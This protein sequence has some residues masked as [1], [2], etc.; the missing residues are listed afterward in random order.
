MRYSFMAG[1]ALSALTFTT[2]VFAEDAGSLARSGEEVFDDSCAGCHTGGFAGFFGGAPEL[3]DKDDWEA[4]IPKGVDG[5]TAST[6]TGIGK[7]AA[8]GGC[9]DCL[10]EEIRAAVEYMFEAVQ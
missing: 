3:G 1:I 7:M 10:D 6:I 4:L 9:D 2:A 8:R 5:L